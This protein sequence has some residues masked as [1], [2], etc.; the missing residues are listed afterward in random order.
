LLDLFAFGAFANWLHLRHPFEED[1]LATTFSGTDR[2]IELSS[3]QRFVLGFDFDTFCSTIVLLE[4]IGS[5]PWYFFLPTIG[6]TH[7]IVAAIGTNA[8]PRTP[9]PL[10]RSVIF[11]LLLHSALRT[12]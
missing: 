9:L 10:C 11:L 6:T 1:M 3:L 5:Q 4:S 2:A 12:T 7:P 8:L